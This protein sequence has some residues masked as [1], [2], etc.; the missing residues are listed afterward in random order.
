MSSGYPAD[1]LLRGFLMAS[2]WSVLSNRTCL[3]CS[4]PSPDQQPSP[5]WSGHLLPEHDGGLCDVGQHICNDK[6]KFPGFFCDVTTCIYHVGSL[7]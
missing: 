1:S 3:F 2:L 6:S 7:S 5:P 4:A